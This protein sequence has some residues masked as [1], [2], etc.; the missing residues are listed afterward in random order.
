MRLGLGPLSIELLRV[1]TVSPGVT[2]RAGLSRVCSWTGVG[3]IQP[4]VDEWSHAVGLGDGTQEGTG[5]GLLK[6]EVH[7]GTTCCLAGTKEG[8]NSGMVASGEGLL[9]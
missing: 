4:R 3:Y 6:I 9:T 8:V 2:G 1:G 7:M 5:L